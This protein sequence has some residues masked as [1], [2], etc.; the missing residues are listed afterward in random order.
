MICMIRSQLKL[1]VEETD[2]KLLD[3]ELSPIVKPISSTNISNNKIF[4][5]QKIIKYKQDK[6]QSLIVHREYNSHRLNCSVCNIN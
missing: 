4:N 2:R 6:E 5:Y 3:Y 1:K